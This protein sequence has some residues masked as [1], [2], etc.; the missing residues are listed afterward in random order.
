MSVK[1]DPEQ[2]HVIPLRMVCSD[3]WEPVAYD[4][5]TETVS[6][7]TEGCECRGII[8]IHSKEIQKSEQIIR[9]HQAQEALG[10][11][12]QLSNKTEA[13]LLAELGF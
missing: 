5:K 12:R 11:T 2:A 8:S 3:C 13:Q 6:C 7:I 1:I 10:I 4:R 9:L